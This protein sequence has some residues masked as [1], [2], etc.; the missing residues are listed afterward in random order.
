MSPY[1]CGCS[2]SRAIPLSPDD[3]APFVAAR[4]AAGGVDVARAAAMAL[5]EVRRPDAVAA[6]RERLPVEDRPDVRHAII[7]ALATSRADGAFD[8]L[9]ELVGRGAAA[10]SQAAVEALRLFP[11]DEALQRRVQVA[12]DGRRPASR[13]PRRRR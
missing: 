10:D 7:L 2:R 4:L 3:A 12:L 5:G 6:L 8:V 11:H 1:S 13:R 9:L